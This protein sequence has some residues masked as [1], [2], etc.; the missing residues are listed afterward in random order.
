M[1]NQSLMFATGI[2]P[3]SHTIP[4]GRTRIDRTDWSGNA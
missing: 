2:E 1:I 4:N 3:N